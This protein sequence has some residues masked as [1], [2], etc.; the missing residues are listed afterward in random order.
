MNASQLTRSVIVV[1]LLLTPACDG[2][3][4]P[5]SGD[6]G[7][8]GTAGGTAGGSA[9]GTAGGSAGGTAGGSAGGR[10]GGSAGGTAGG[11]AGG[12]AGGSAGGRAGGSAG[13]T[14]GGSAGGRAGGSAGGTAGGTASGGGIASG[15]DGGMTNCAAL[16]SAC[17]YPDST[18][19]GPAPGTTFVKVPQQLTAGSGWA[20]EANFSRLRV[21]GSNAVLDGLEINGEMVIDA[22]GVTIKNS[23]IS[24][25]G[26][27]SGVITIRAGRPQ[28]GYLGTNASIIHNTIRCVGGTRTAKGVIDAYG[29]GTGMLVKGNDISGVGNCVSMEAGGVAEDNWCHD[30]GH[31]SGDHHSGF[32]NH[33]GASGVI[34][35]HNTALL[36]NT[37]TSGGGGLSGAITIYGDFARAQHVTAQDNLLSGGAYTMYGGINNEATYGDPLDVKLISNR[38]VCNRWVY[39]PMFV[40]ATTIVSGNFCDQNRAPVNP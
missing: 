34:F 20:W 28:D 23:I 4:D 25:C 33:G 11:S 38:L 13:G 5:P 37:P 31:I 9:G 22:P 29:G 12:T 24:A 15:T 27:Q 2:T 14:A 30:L 6:A 17:G 32:S 16:P 36:A 39:G 19:T 8:G 26:G 7:A 3:M 35:R 18:N 21:T 10:A 40:R 1:A